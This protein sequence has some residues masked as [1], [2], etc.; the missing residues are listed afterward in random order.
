MPH[1]T[2]RILVCPAK[3]A[4][5]QYAC[6]CT[7][8][9][10]MTGTANITLLVCSACLLSALCHAAQVAVQEIQAFRQ[11]SPQNAL[12][13]STFTVVSQVVLSLVGI[14]LWLCCSRLGLHTTWSVVG[15][16][17]LDLL[18]AIGT[19]TEGDPNTVTASFGERS[20][21]TTDSAKKTNTSEIRI[22]VIATTG[23]CALVLLV[24]GYAM[25]VR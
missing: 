12:H 10:K 4:L 9:T 11:G 14:L 15:L 19:T 2:T 23:C 18:Q 25:F 13:C 21:G 24:L 22:V 17:V 8:I 1:S 6:T 3:K 16:A 5:M 7:Y 20:N